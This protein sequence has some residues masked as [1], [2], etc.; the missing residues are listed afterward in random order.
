MPKLPKIVVSL[1]E[2]IFLK[3]IEYLPSTFDIYPPL[4]NS[5]FYE[6]PWPKF[7][8]SIDRAARNSADN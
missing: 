5:L 3:Q 7:L 1:R 2:I 8:F 4:V 6:L